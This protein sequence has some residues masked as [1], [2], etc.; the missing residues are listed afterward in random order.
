[1][2]SQG[3]KSICKLTVFHKRFEFVAL[4][5]I[6]NCLSHMDPR[7]LYHVVKDKPNTSYK[8]CFCWHEFLILLQWWSV[9][10]LCVL[11]HC[12]KYVYTCVIYLLYTEKHHKANL[13]NLCGILNKSYLQYIF[14]AEKDELNL[15]LHC[16][17]SLDRFICSAEVSKWNRWKHK[18]AQL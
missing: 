12:H 8:S 4:F 11:T 7:T 10:R 5:I 16:Y 13:L 6:A 15:C 14:K 2:F 9:V 18:R 3:K 1:M 17:F